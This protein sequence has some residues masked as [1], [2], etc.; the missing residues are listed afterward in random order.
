MAAA[1]PWSHLELEP[2]APAA[3]VDAATADEARPDAATVNEA[4]PD[5]SMASTAA[6]PEADKFF[7]DAL[8]QKVKVYAGAGVVAGVSV[9]LTIGVHKLIKDHSHRAYVSAFL[10]TSPASL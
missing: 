2:A 3:T 4:R 9:G 10:H 6:A 1:D 8:K 7:N 5:A